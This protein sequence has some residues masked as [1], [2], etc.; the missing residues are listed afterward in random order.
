MISGL[1]GEGVVTVRLP[2]TEAF[3][4]PFLPPLPKT[5]LSLILKLWVRGRGKKEKKK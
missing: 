4:I 5:R 1:R 2:H 3:F